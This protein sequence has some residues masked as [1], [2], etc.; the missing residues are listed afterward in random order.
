MAKILKV[1]GREVLDS[2][3]N[4]TVEVEVLLDDGTK[5]R[6]I[7]PSGASTGWYSLETDELLYLLY[8][9]NDADKLCGELTISAGKQIPGLVILPDLWQAPDG[10]SFDAKAHNTCDKTTWE[11]MQTAGAVFLPAA[12]YREL[13]EYKTVDTDA[14]GK[15]Y[16]L[17][18]YN[19]KGK[20]SSYSFVESLFFTIHPDKEINITGG[21]AVPAGCGQA[22]R[23]V[24][25]F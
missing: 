3:G 25:Q 23:L 11:K 20:L 16:R 1:H 21:Q 18:Y 9:R 4:P 10:V 17:G 7:V 6:A 22:V 19:I 14:A 13:G 5:A 2:R 12:G 15:E 8:Q 24:R